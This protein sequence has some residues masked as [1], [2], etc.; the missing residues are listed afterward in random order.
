MS[1][2]DYGSF[3]TSMTAASAKSLPLFPD[4]N[5]VIYMFI[6]QVHWVL[7]IPSA[8]LVSGLAAGVSTL[9]SLWPGLAACTPGGPEQR[10]FGYQVTSTG[11]RYGFARSYRVRHTLAQSILLPGTVFL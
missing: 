6:T 9:T 4:I 8:L 3:E 5:D 10:M 2:Q 7:A 1:L 11:C